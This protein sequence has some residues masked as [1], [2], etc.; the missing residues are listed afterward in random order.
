[1]SDG[2]TSM[3]R[4]LL[5]TALLVGLAFVLAQGIKTF[6]VQPFLVPSGSMLPTIQLNDRLLAE[7]IS[8]RFFRE[9]RPGD[10]VVFDNPDKSNKREKIF[11]KRVIA[12]EGQTVD[13]KDG[14]VLVDGKRLDERYTRGKPTEPGSISLPAVVPEDHVWLM[15]DNRTGSSDSRVFG[16]RPVSTVRGRAFCIYWPAER[17]GALR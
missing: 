8:L 14:R 11:I 12:I 7:K 16:A 17:V 15:G 2:N 10:V 6:I 9:P 4:W 1:M 5:E 13:V 3:G